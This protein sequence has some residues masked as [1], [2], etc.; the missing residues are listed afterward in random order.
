M[1]HLRLQLTVN[2]PFQAS[3]HVLLKRHGYF[4]LLGCDFMLSATN[5]L[6]MLEI[7]TN[8]SLTLG[9]PDCFQAPHR[10]CRLCCLLT[11]RMLTFLLADNS[12]LAN[13]LPDIVDGAI[14]LVMQS[15]G[16]DRRSGESD[17]FLKA[18]L[19]GKF[20][21]I[22]DE[23]TGFMYKGARKGKSSKATKAAHVSAADGTTG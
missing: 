6:S 16:P 9:T 7:N 17:D 1:P 18:D 2:Y 21:L 5:K 10:N 14:E 11:V 15:Q 3:N 4:D 22:Y 12:T 13:M 19:P 8:P 20:S 23:G